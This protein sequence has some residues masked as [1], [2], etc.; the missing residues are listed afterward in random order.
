[1]KKTYRLFLILGLGLCLLSGCSEQQEQPQYSKE[2]ILDTFCLSNATRENCREL[3][4]M[5]MEDTKVQFLSERTINLQ[6]KRQY[7]LEVM[8]IDCD[9]CNNTMPVIEEYREK[10]NIPIYTCVFADDP[11]AVRNWLDENDYHTDIGFIEYD[12]VKETYG[13]KYTPCFL[14]VED[15]TVKMAYIGEIDSTEQLEQFILTAFAE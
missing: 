3:D 8:N 7:I 11:E 10:A 12:D 2:E 13:I 5:K 9:H 15:S 14:F 1:M 4:G 6:Q